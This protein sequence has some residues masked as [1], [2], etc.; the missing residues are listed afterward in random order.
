MKIVLNDT[1]K[2]NVQLEI[3][4]TGT[5]IAAFHQ[6]TADCDDLAAC[7]KLVLPKFV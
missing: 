2:L 6:I 7:S 4:M 1:N 5:K 3:I